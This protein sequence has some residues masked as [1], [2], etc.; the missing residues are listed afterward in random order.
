M[1]FYSEMA[2]VADQLLAE[3]GYDS[4]I[5]AADT[6]SDPVTGLGGS[7]GA[8]RAVRAVQ[9]KMDYKVFPESLVQTGDRMFLFG[10]QVERGE[11]LVDGSTEW[12]IAQVQHIRPDNAT[13]IL[14]KALVRG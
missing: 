4:N 7:D 9:T 10:G 5:R 6:P 12:A 8:T 3:F 1:T 11:K 14:S 2:A 13:H